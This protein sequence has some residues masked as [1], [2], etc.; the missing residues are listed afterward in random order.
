MDISAIA[1]F[2]K[3]PTL[4]IFLTCIISGMFLFLTESF[5]TDL[6][7]ISFEKDYKKWVTVVF[8]FSLGF[9]VLNL[10][11][12]AY[13]NYQK[14]YQEKIVE[15]EINEHKKDSLKK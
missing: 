10:L 3:S 12:M 13:K 6:E 15:A 4:Y 7:L 14:N 5:L 8:L 1:K 2:I 11:N 9:F